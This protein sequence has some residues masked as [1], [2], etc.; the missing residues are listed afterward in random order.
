MAR[1]GPVYLSVTSSADLKALDATNQKLRNL[2]K[3][4]KTTGSGFSGFGK[5]LAGIGSVAG[6]IGI[7]TKALTEAQDAFK[8]SAATAQILKNTGLAA[9]VSAD[10][11]GNLAMQIS[12]LTGIDDENI[13]AASN[14][15][16]SIKGLIPAGKDAQSTLQGLTQVA[17]DLG[18]KLGKD[19]VAGARILAKALADPT[20]AQRLFLGALIPM[21]KA[22]ADQ[23]KALTKAG[24]AAS[25]RQLILDHAAASTSGM[26]AAV[27]DPMTKLSTNLNN[28]FETIGTPLLNALTQIT[29]ELTNLMNVG[30]PIFETIANAVANTITFITK[31][32]DEILIATAV[33]GISVIALNAGKIGYFLFATGVDAAAVA[34]RVFNAVMNANPLAK[35]V[36]VLS[37]LIAAFAVLWK[38]SM[39]FRKIVA[40]AFEVVGKVAANMVSG[41]LKGFALII[42]GIRWIAEKYLTVVGFMVKAA[43]KIFG[44]VPGLGKVLKT[45]AAGFDAFRSSVLD[46]LDGAAD[47]LTGWGDSLYATIDN[48]AQA[49]GTNIRKSTKQTK[50]AVKNDLKDIG[51]LTVPTPQM[52]GVGS[53][54]KPT[55]AMNRPAVGNQAFTV[56]G[57]GGGLSLSVTVNGSVIQERDI[58]RTIRDELLQFARRQGASP[59]FGV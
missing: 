25:A 50:A 41:I 35:V 3:T 48:A 56:A 7:G 18:A 1:K 6:L 45:A 15:F 28:L 23:V 37:L 13:Q 22:L 21:D 30:A 8:V 12:N 27:A 34:Q 59:A 58:A 2:A 52:S 20:K 31:F 38:R 11:I 39:T 47:T 26:A 14:L 5:A 24:D 44:W 46:G 53:K 32:K 36:M 40:A 43:A 17:T 16:L 42:R 33:I 49:V 54:A 9:S 55:T 57:S 4:A 10:Q 51:K 29:P 19:P